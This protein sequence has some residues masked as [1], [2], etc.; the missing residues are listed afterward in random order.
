MMVNTDS[1]R[2]RGLLLVLAAATCAVSC[3]AAGAVVPSLDSA[4]AAAE[5]AVSSSDE[6]NMEAE[7]KAFVEQ[8]RLEAELAAAKRKLEKTQSELRRRKTAT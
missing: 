4:A 3:S 6:D 5:T 8:E 2:Q 1:L 7:D